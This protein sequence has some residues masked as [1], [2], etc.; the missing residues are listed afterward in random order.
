MRRA[1]KATLALLLLVRVAAALAQTPPARISVVFT[2]VDENG[3]AVPD[4]EVLVEE[5][6]R[7]P[8]RLT[9]GYSGRV[10]YVLQGSEPYVIEVRKPGFYASTGNEGNPQ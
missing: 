5:P 3:I 6:G 10:T 7:V 9:T 2:V 1:W 8:A 4:A